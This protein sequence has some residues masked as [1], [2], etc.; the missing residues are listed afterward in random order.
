MQNA[1][2]SVYI[3]TWWLIVAIIGMVLMVNIR[4]ASDAIY[5]RF[6]ERFSKIGGGVG[7]RGL[8]VVGTIAFLF[9]TIGFTVE[10]AAI[11]AHH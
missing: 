11:M 7:P 3:F 5:L 8:R 9:G 10:G 1:G 2:E 6:E 4:G